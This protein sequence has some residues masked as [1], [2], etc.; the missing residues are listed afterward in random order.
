M[1]K[2]YVFWR[3][4]N[5]RPAPEGNDKYAP[6]SLLSEYGLR[7][8]INANGGISHSDILIFKL[9]TALKSAVII[10]SPE[11]EELNETDSWNILR[12]S[13]INS[14]K[15]NGGKKALEN[16][17][18]L[19]EA[20]QLAA[21][22]FRKPQIPYTLI[23]SLSIDSFPARSIK[24]GKC[25]ISAAPSLSLF[26]PPKCIQAY[27]NLADHRASSRYKF[28]RI[29]ISGRSYSEA[30]SQGLHALHLLRG[31]WSIFTTPRWSMSFGGSRKDSLGTI[32][33]GPVHTLHSQDGKPVAD[34]LWID[35]GW[36]KDQELFSLKNDEWKIVEKNRRQAMRQLKRNKLGF[37]REIENLIV[38]YAL[39]LDQCDHDV[40][41]LQMWSI[42]EKLTDTV[43]AKYDETVKRA[44]WPFSKERT[45]RKE[46][47]NCMRSQRN[48]YVHA[49][50]SRSEA[51]QAAYLVKEFVDVHLLMI[52][53]NY[54]NV[55]DIQEY[56]RLLTYPT[57]SAVLKSQRVLLGKIMR[58]LDFQNKSQ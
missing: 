47:L 22:F 56:A 55:A 27:S 21:E 35:P 49:S 28:V 34:M 16:K 24:I 38:R 33:T 31:L 29:S 7:S 2:R 1:S 6:I 42:L 32:H 37:Q 43:G 52:M 48:L 58:A 11:G 44:T 36:T 19:D 15:K 14:V 3:Q 26:P 50:E 54:F 45:L 20:D 13:L 4:S 51:D 12:R 57:D 53:K 25:Q 18:L 30:V 40:A 10:L 8:S 9:E 17:E 5:G 39:A 23:G 46:M 41:F